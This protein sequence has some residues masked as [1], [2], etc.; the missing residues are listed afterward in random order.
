MRRERARLPRGATLAAFAAALFLSSVSG[1]AGAYCR[2]TTCGLPAGFAP[3]AGECYPPDFE[4]RCASLDTPVK[5]LPLY[6]A[7]ACVSY[8]IQENAS[9]QVPYAQAV[10]L[11]AAA[12]SQ[13]TSTA[14][15]DDANGGHVSIQATD[16]G[17][18]ACDQVQYSADQGNQHVIIFHDDAWPHDDSSNTL[19]LTTITFDPDTGEIY[20]ADMEINST[21]EIPLSLG[22]PPAG[23]YD[24]QSI[25]QHETGHFLGLAHSGEPGATMLAR[26]TPGTTSMRTLSSDDIAG[27]CSVYLADG[28]RAVATSVAASGLVAPDACDPAPRHGFQSECAQPVPPD[29]G[30]KCSLAGAPGMPQG[31]GRGNLAAT[32]A[33]VAA[34]SA[35]FASRR[36]R[37]SARA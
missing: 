23:G 10:T 11:F 14:C 28:D 24:F 34:I 18:V 19:G 12:F 1:R 7:N 32:G 31:D 37:A 36:R 35:L 21:P 22:D 5:V 25:I 26:Y 8:D 20:D 13:W 30:P 6:W 3:S 17:P 9:V 33:L 16:L 2:T 15:P 4:E 27:I 29:S